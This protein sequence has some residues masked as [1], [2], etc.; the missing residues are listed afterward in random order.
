[1]PSP[2]SSKAQREGSQHVP[3]G[4]KDVDAAGP[5]QSKKSDGEEH[6]NE[7][8]SSTMGRNY[9][10]QGS[11]PPP[12][13]A[14]SEAKSNHVA[15]ENEKVAMERVQSSARFSGS[16]QDAKRGTTTLTASPTAQKAQSSGKYVDAG[17]SDVLPIMSS[18]TTTNASGG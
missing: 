15:A 1:Q 9:Q 13:G 6:Q 17:K 18:G 7:T 12:R 4:L 14:K 10:G 3:G 8:G 16:G 2:G 11:S 5:E